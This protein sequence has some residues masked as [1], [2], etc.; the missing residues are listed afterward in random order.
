MA[1][2]NRVQKAQRYALKK[3]RETKIFCDLQLE[4]RHPSDPAVPG[5]KRQKVRCH[6]TIKELER[7]LA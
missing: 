6:D 3:A 4:S 5:L 1:S 7:A 2:K